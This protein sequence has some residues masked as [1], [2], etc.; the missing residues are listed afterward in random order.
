MPKYEPLSV[1]LAGRGLARE[2]M[3]F[4]EIERVIG[5]S[6]PRSARDHAAWWGNELVPGSHVQSRAWLEAGY[7]VESIDR[8]SGSVTFVRAR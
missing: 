2:I 7:R 6:L 3:T 1:H 5:A 4:A 8:R